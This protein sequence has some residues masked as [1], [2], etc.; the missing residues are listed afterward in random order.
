MLMSLPSLHN[1]SSESNYLNSMKVERPA[2]SATLAAN[3]RALMDKRA[4]TQ[5]ELES[6]SGVSQRHIS[7]VLNQ[8]TGCSAETADALASAFGLPGWLLLVPGLSL[9]LLDSH[10]VLLL[11]KSFVDAGPEG[12]ELV[13]RLAEREATHNREKHKVIPFTKRKQP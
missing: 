6:K 13:A 7:N 12:R 3:I 1:S 8:R 11:V 5:T 9:E 10:S 2:V 4:W